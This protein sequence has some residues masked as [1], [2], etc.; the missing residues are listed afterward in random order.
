MYTNIVL[1]KPEA[2][3]KEA[4]KSIVQKKTC[5]AIIMN[6]QVPVGL[7][8]EKDVVSALSFGQKIESITLNKI[9]SSPVVIVKEMDTVAQGVLTL[10]ANHIHRAVVTDSEDKVVGTFALN[11]VVDNMDIVLD[12]KL[13]SYSM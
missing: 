5:C 12:K 6:G 9:M 8:S 3:L 11:N 1:E 4:G 10:R 13:M 2:T 7:T